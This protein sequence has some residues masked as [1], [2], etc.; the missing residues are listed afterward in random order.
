MALQDH[1]QR[2][3]PGIRT[4]PADVAVR[5]VEEVRSHWPEHEAGLAKSPELRREIGDRIDF[6]STRLLHSR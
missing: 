2:R 6:H 4:N 3:L 5:T 1:L